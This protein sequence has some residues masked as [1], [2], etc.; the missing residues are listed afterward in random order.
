MTVHLW[1]GS[2]DVLDL[3]D[4]TEQGMFSPDAPQTWTLNNPAGDLATLAPGTYTATIDVT[5]AD[6]DQT[7]GGL[8]PT[9]PGPNTLASRSRRRAASVLS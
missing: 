9:G 1:S 7:A 5:D 2:T 4:L 8:T 6:S 3:S